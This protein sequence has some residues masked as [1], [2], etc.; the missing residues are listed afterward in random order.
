MPD[1]IPLGNP[2]PLSDDDLDELAK[3]TP[4]D[5]EDAKKLWKASVEPEVEDL[6]DTTETVK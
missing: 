6:L 1:K 3:V 4:E 2:L 5:I